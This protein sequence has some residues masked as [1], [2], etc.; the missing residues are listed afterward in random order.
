[1]TS[2]KLL[3]SEIQNFRKFYVTVTVPV[4]FLVVEHQFVAVKY[5]EIIIT[6]SL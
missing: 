6:R 2:Q 4:A 5:Y 3:I 1:M